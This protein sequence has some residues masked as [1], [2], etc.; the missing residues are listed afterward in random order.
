MIYLAKKDF[1]KR[2]RASIFTSIEDVS[3]MAD[4]DGIDVGSVDESVIK[5]VVLITLVV[6]VSSSDVKVELFVEKADVVVS[7]SALVVDSKLGIVDESKVDV[8]FDTVVSF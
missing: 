2:N 4:V 3:S 5:D 1:K 7:I 8:V 6:D